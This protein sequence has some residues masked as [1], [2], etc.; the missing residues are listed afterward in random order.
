M[1]LPPAPLPRRAPTLPPAV[2][3]CLA[4]RISRILVL[5]YAAYTEFQASRLQADFSGWRAT[6]SSPSS[7]AQLVHRFPQRPYD[8][9]RLQ[10]LPNFLKR[11]SHGYTSI[12]GAA[13]TSSGIDRSRLRPA[14]A[15]KSGRT[16]AWIVAPTAVIR[17]PERF[18]EF[19]GM[20]PHVVR[21]C[22]SSRTAS[23]L[24]THPPS[25]PAWNGPPRLAVS[26]IS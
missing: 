24:T 25:H 21:P 15:K 8:S 19:R 7:L 14:Y 9:A 26:G 1:S 20:P 3:N 2:P 11:S 22:F 23:F 6:C 13:L 17:H 10:R 18:T 4:V 12:P 5:S 16:A